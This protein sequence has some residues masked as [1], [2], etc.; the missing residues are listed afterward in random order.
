MRCQRRRFRAVLPVGKGFLTG[1]ITSE[2]NFHESDIRAHNPRFSNAA[3]TANQ[4][5]VT[6]IR[7]VAERRGCSPAQVALAWVMAQGDTVVP[8][9]GTKRVRHLEENVC[10]ADVCLSEGEM[11]ELAALPAPIGTRY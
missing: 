9:P 7:D 6:G 11:A 8:I 4:S 10:A 3:I 2:T 5:I 1:T